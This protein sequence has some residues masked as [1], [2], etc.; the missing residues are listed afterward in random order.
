MEDSESR[1]IEASL[2]LREGE[3]P[4]SVEV[5]IPTGGPYAVAIYSGDRPLVALKGILVG[6]IWVLAGQSNMQGLGEKIEGLPPLERSTMLS[7]DRTWKPSV[8]PLHRFWETKDTAQYKMSHFLGFDQ[9]SEQLDQMFD[10]LHSRDA[11]EPV[12]GVGPGYFFARELIEICDLPVGLIPCALGGSP[13]DMWEKSYAAEHSLDFEDT[14]YGDLVDRVR[15]AGGRVAGVAWYQGES[16]AL[17]EES[18]TYLGRFQRFV[19]DLRRD[20][21]LPDFPFITVQLATAENMEWAGESNWERIREAQRLASERIPHVELVAAADLPRIDDVH[22]SAEGHRLLGRRL[23]MAA[24]GSALGSEKGIS[25]PR[26][27]GVGMTQDGIE[28][29][30]SGVNGAL[31][32]SPEARLDECLFVSENSILGVEIS[33]KDCVSVHLAKP[34][35]SEQEIFYGRGFRPPVGLVDE[36]GFAMPLFGPVN[37]SA[38][39]NRLERN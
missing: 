38:G 22:I 31:R 19:T 15:R 37:A 2:E 25:I 4:A 21:G 35:T 28:V 13:L 34:V 27:R 11:V 32:A 3:G 18:K 23:A 36:A 16:D 6:D 30:F 8:E 29:R 24:S 9:T 7:F 39:E 20:L 1:P 17:P 10:E 26:L 12:G 14:L 33:F 5:I